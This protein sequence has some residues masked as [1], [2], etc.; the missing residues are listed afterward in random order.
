[1]AETRKKVPMVVR[2]IQ[3]VT[4]T[5][6]KGYKLTAI[7]FP[8]AVVSG[9]MNVCCEGRGDEWDW[10]QSH[11]LE[12]GRSYVLVLVP[13]PEDYDPRLEAQDRCCDEGL[14]PAPEPQ[15]QRP[16]RE[17]GL[18]VRTEKLDLER[19]RGVTQRLNGLLE[20]NEQGLATWCEFVGDT[21][22]ELWEVL[23]VRA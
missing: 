12:V 17:G 6:G 5:Q 15:S 18:W 16:E 4:T 7:D 9:S 8:R 10:T 20:A 13:V 19:L 2:C 11:E 3:C 22:K 14:E 21:V 23:A 1:M